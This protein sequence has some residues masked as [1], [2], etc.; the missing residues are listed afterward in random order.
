M[1]LFVSKPLDPATV[2]DAV[3]LS[4]NGVLVE[5]AVTVSGNGTAIHFDPAGNLTPRR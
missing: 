2:A 5:G 1:T 4:Q 3:Y